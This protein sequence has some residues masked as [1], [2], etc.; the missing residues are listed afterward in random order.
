VAKPPWHLSSATPELTETP[1]SNEE[2]TSILTQV[3]QSVPGAPYFLIRDAQIRPFDPSSFDA[4]HDILG[5]VDPSSQPHNP[6]WPLRNLLAF[7]PSNTKTARVLC[8][9]DSEIP[10]DGW[11]SRYAVLE[12]Q[13]GAEGTQG[14]RPDAVGW[15]KNPH[16]KLAPRVVDLAPMMDPTRCVSLR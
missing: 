10:R 11:K 8:W 16:G 12:R 2:M 13:T 9:R 15:E 1:F 4:Q 7:I 6:G 5:F 3:T 14:A